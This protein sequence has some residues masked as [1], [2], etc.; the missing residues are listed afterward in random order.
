M[1]RRLTL[2]VVG[3]VAATL[4]LVGAVTV[5]LARIGARDATERD[6]RDEVSTLADNVEGARAAPLRAMQRALHLDGLAFVLVGRLGV[7]GTLPD[8]VTRDDL[9]P[10]R[11]AA[12]EVVT[13][14]HGDLVYAASLARIEIATRQGALVVI[15]TRNADAGLGRSVR[16]FVVA[17]LATLLIGALVARAVGRR[18]GEP[19]RAAD[20]AA[21]RI[22]AGDLTTRVPE[23]PSHRDDE[24]GGLSRAVN[25]MAAALQQSR[26]HER[27]FLLSVS[28]DL[29]TP[30]TSIGGYAEALADGTETDVE[31]A[32]SVILAE[33]RRL[34]RLVADL[35]DLAKL[36]A[37][38][39]SFA[40]DD[41]DLAALVRDGVDAFRPA[42][43]DAGLTLAT[44]PD[45]DEATAIAEADRDRLAQVLANLLEN[46]TRFARTRIDVGVAHDAARDTVAFTVDDD[47]PGLPPTD[48]SHA[49]DRLYAPERAPARRG[50]GSGLGLAIVRELV[51]GMGGTVTAGP[52]PAGGARFE[53]RLPAA[54]RNH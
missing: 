29:R 50:P 16:W 22:A 53:V 10:A 38:R 49:F 42:A 19:I 26:E 20:N 8:G 17:A 6:L 48:A 36:D 28:H 30:L 52:S 4:L 43:R 33:A 21:R 3:V 5:G 37:H 44:S 31:R 27:Q 15:A 9:D 14:S 23:G 41:V 25:D 7:A 13:G 45:T 18:I 39:F 40:H 2:L 47:G 24:L 12:G 32:A 34:E 1:R 54:R 11:L 46:A 35:L 51:A